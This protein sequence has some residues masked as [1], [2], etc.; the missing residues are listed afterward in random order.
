MTR[1][2]EIFGFMTLLVVMGLLKPSASHNLG[3]GR[4]P[5]ATTAVEDFDADRVREVRVTE[6]YIR[7]IRI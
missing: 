4:C 5:V 2:G 6:L 3:L 7:I 1:L